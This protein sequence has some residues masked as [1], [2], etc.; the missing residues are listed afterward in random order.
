[1]VL[2]FI[3]YLLNLVVSKV[4]QV[5]LYNIP[6]RLYYAVSAA[7]TTITASATTR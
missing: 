1:M 4:V 5:K 2:L 7:G 3:I 6:C